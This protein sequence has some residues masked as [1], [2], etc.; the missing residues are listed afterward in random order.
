M[1]RDS[2]E[3][4]QEQSRR[5][6][7]NRQ[8]LRGGSNQPDERRQ[9]RGSE[10]SNNRDNYDNGRNERGWFD[11][12][13]DEVSSWF[14]GDNSNRSRDRNLRSNGNENEYERD[15]I[16]GYQA[17][18]TPKEANPFY[19]TTNRI[20]QRGGNS[21][22]FT[23][24][25]SSNQDYQPNQ[26]RDFNKINQNRNF[27]QPRGFASGGSA[28]M[29]NQ[30]NQLQQ[31]RWRDW[32]DTRAGDLMTRNVA[33]VHPNDTAQHAARL[34]RDEDCGALPVI[35]RQGR[36]IGMVT[37]RDIT[38]RIVADG[39]DP[40]FALVQDCM[41]DEVFACHADDPIE[42]CIR[43]MKQHQVRRMPIVNDRNQLLGIVSQGDLIRHAEMNKNQG[44]RHAL[45]NMIAE[46]SEPS[47]NAYR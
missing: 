45:T 17:G 24:N 14:G 43:Q 20:Q 6:F 32:H 7:G 10:Q 11:K 33:T 38:I 44:E 4:L 29:Q 2:Y 15:D 5:E 26:N 1:R 8:D 21:E 16:H 18:H 41:T 42:A 3:R 25:D 27:N 46:V 30:N 34:M 23:G 22:R 31:R 13:S 47:N 12:A 35:D 36:M 19:P 39:V 9:I 37:D 28:S 40:R